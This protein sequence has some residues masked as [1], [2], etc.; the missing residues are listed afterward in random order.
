MASAY[1]VVVIGS[2]LGGLC[3]AFETAR[4]GKRT[5][6]LE[7][8]NLPGGFATSFVRGR[9]EF[10]SSLHE[11]PDMRSVADATGVVRYLQDDAALDID[12]LPVPEAYRL[13]LTEGGVDARLPFG[14]EAFISAIEAQVPGS[15][16]AVSRYMA[17]CAQVQD[18]F[19]YLNTAGTRPDPGKLLR[20]YGDFLRT[21]GATAAQVARSLDMPERAMDLIYPYWCY[22]GVPADRL[23]FSIW[24]ALVNSY[25]SA[26]AVI[27]RLRSHEIASAFVRGIEKAGG[28]IRL[29]ARVAK[30]LCR[31]GAVEGVE[32]ADGECYTADAVI[33][34]ASPTVV[35]NEL[36]WPKAQVPAAA[37]RNVR[38]RKSGLSLVVV[39]LGLDAAPEELA[40][41]DYSYFIAPHMR[42][43]E[44]YENTKDLESDD[45]MQASV[46]LNAANPGCSPPGTAILALTAGYRAEAWAGVG[47]GDYFATKDR[48][49]RRLIE[50]FE[51]A[52]GTDIV[53]HIEEIEVATPET[54]ARY[55]G[56]YDGIVYGYEP[57]PW[58]GIVPR[59]LAMERESY[60]D[61]LRFCGGFSY[62]CHGYGS[63]I[64]SGKKAAQLA[65]SDLARGGRR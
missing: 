60:L 51:R 65:L 52:T 58:D 61:G 17:L 26:G 1:D 36:V 41:R 45:I 28:D 11:M 25:V 47:E 50:Q 14:R 49:A 29:N 15:R 20:D 19:Q 59:A 48:V 6:L 57:E 3:A 18:A 44:L 40:L 2:G 10:E 22:L 63:S 35:F 38:S 39:Y 53:P 56:A 62:R 31:D 5:L 4:A 30:I 7:R 12:F 43:E 27:P 9:F 8:H 64:L 24:A 16:E 21:G 46:C 54:F 55:T 13:I 33:T 32:T 23:S 37:M 34:N 42:T